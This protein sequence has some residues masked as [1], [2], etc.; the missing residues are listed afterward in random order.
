MVRQ[1]VKA[2]GV[3]TIHV[4]GGFPEVRGH[5]AEW[6]RGRGRELGS[7]DE[8]TENLKGEGR[9]ER[10]RSRAGYEVQRSTSNINTRPTLDHRNTEY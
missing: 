7:E 2:S 1:T 6:E 4:H 5:Y 8:R 10:T 3:N 9:G